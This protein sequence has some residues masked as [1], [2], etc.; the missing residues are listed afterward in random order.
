MDTFALH[1]YM[2]HATVH[3]TMSLHPSRGVRCLVAAT[4]VVVRDSSREAKTNSG[5]RIADL[6]LSLHGRDEKDL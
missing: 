6:A 4:N 1:E 5:G 2:K 3:G